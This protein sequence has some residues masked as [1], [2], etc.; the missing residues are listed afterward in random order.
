MYDELLFKTIFWPCVPSLH[1]SARWLNPARFAL[2]TEIAQLAIWKSVG[3]AFVAADTK[4]GLA[5]KG[6]GSASSLLLLQLVA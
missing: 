3:I 5:R 4:E 6:R 2:G 1:D